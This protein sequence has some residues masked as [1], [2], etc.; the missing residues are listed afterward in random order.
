MAQIGKIYQS[1]NTG[2]PFEYEFLDQDYQTLYASEQRIATLSKYF[3]VLA[4]VISCL[5]LFGLAAFSAQRRQK[6]IGIRKVVGATAGNIVIL[7]STDF[8]KLVL[9]GM[10][11]AFPIAWWTTE[12]WLK[13]FAYH[14][15]NS[16]N[17]YWFTGLAII[18]ITLMTV[19]YQA[20]KAA[21]LN[22]VKSLKTE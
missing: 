5:G 8:L 6:E 10:L 18:A 3:A 13:N 16:L 4:I 12:K 22:P 11:V 19:S 2:L 15:D 20:I 17:T 7:L 1:Y 14:T 21:L 9:M